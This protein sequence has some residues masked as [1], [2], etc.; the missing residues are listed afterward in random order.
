MRNIMLLIINTLKVTFRKKGNFI[1][2]LL[3]PL[4]GVLLSMAIYTGGSDKPLPVGVVDNDT[5]VLS[6]DFTVA[7]NSSRGYT[8]TAINEADGKE[9]LLDGSL[10]A[11]ITIPSGY[12]DSIYR[13]SPMK[14]ELMS[15]KGKDA[16]V[17]L[18]H[19]ID[20]YTK[21]LADLSTAS[22]GD[23]AVFDR[24]YAQYKANPLK[25]AEEHVADKQRS[26]NMTVTS[27]G[28]LIMFVMMGAGLTTNFILNEKRNR[29]YYRI[30]SAPVNQWQYIMSNAVTS[31][32]IVSVQIIVLLLVLTYVFHVETY[33]PGPVMFLILFMFG[34][35]AVGISLLIAAFSSSSYMSGTLNSVIMT[36]TCMLGGCFWS[37]DYMPK[38]MQKIAYFTPQ[39]WTIEAVQ[40]IQ[41]G[42]G[43]ENILMNLLILAAFAAAMIAIAAYRFSRTGSIQKFV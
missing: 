13:N 18:E 20:L 22:G 42:V 7:V 10:E 28:F 16:T 5:S 3:L 17:W 24:L 19:Y 26:K 36:P 21:N 11:V 27:V 29:T 40:K 1:V 6:G 31:L 9:K 39:R 2:Y 32:L 25:L 38:V 12:S 30:C 37:V 4:T 14:M 15:V 33:V 41:T 34:L 8:A 43:F 35:A 23:K